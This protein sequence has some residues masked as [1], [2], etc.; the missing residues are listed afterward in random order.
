LY[1]LS[2]RLSR[3]HRELAA[4]MDAVKKHEIP[5]HIADRDRLTVEEG[6]RSIEIV[7]L[8]FLYAGNGI[9]MDPLKARAQLLNLSWRLETGRSRS[10]KNAPLS[11]PKLPNASA[12]AR[13]QAIS[14]MERPSGSG[15]KS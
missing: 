8:Q 13:C 12:S 7:R 11:I 10:R 5:Q 3:H 9:A 4:V 2:A 6:N 14:P 1:G 15:R